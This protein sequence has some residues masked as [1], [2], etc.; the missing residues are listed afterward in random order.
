MTKHFSLE[1]AE[2]VARLKT[3]ETYFRAIHKRIN[4]TLDRFFN[5][6]A[7]RTARNYDRQGDTADRVTAACEAGLSFLEDR[8]RLNTAL[9]S[10]DARCGEASATVRTLTQNVE[11]LTLRV[12]EARDQR[13]SEILAAQKQSVQCEG[14][15]IRAIRASRERWIQRYRQARAQAMQDARFK[16]QA[17]EAHA[18]AEEEVKNLREEVQ[19]LKVFQGKEFSASE[20]NQARQQAADYRR[21]WTELTQIIRQIN[22]ICADAPLNHSQ[23]LP[24]QVLELARRASSIHS[25]LSH[26]QVETLKARACNAQ[27]A[28][29]IIAQTLEGVLGKSNLPIE[30]EVQALAQRFMEVCA[31][32]DNYRA[33]KVELEN[34]IRGLL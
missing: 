13:D 25:G 8:A 17:Q 12:K 21:S 22:S 6:A 9:L 14:G 34:K 3:A 5:T 30:S 15:L 29:N 23:T 7:S 19:R 1:S 2:E 24:Q 32:R 33:A 31:Q 26:T 27:N 16:Q 4:D 11:A 20:L 18:R 28:L 10:A